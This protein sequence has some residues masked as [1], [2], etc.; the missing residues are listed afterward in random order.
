[1]QNKLKSSQHREKVK[2]FISLTQTGEQTAIFCLQQNDWKL[3][4]ASDNYFQNP[5][6]YYVRPRPKHVYG[7]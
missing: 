5:E 6:Y 3:D 4:L 7:S 1:L 2:K